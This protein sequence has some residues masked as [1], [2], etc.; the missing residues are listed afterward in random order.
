MKQDLGYNKEEIMASIF[1]GVSQGL[2]AAS[3]QDGVPL[4]PVDKLLEFHTGEEG[5]VFDV[6]DDDDMQELCEKVSDD[7]KILEPLL[8]R[9]D[10]S[11]PGYYEIISGHRRRHVAMMLGYTE[12]PCIVLEISDADAIKLMVS[13]NIDKRKKIKPSNLARAYKAY[14]EANSRQGYRSD[15]TSA[16]VGQKLG[17]DTSSAQLGQKS[18]GEYAFC[19]PTTRDIAAEVFKT[20][21]SS[22]QRTLRLNYL[23]EPFLSRVD[24]GSLRQGVAEEISYLSQEEQKDLH[25]IMG[26][27]QRTP[28]LE[29][30]KEMHQIVSERGYIEPIDISNIMTRAK[31]AKTI[32]SETKLNKYL[33][34]FMKKAITDDKLA[35]IITALEKYNAELAKEGCIDKIE[36]VDR[37]NSNL[38]PK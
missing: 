29:Q 2:T 4:I 8:V 6:E 22:I 30:A 14:M 18:E 33:P 13:T 28:S 16:Q 19:R 24:N 35:Y 5:H 34:V 15:I 12:L 27:I 20:S 10:N 1:G 7:G 21:K 23:I 26:N 9:A 17:D 11:Y 37:V 32:I 3:G 38:V 25:A 31:K 36:W